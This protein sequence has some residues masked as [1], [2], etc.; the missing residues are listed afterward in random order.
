MPPS[1]DFDALGVSAGGGSLAVVGRL[2]E[3]A[4][5][6]SELDSGGPDGVA[7]ALGSAVASAGLGRGGSAGGELRPRTTKYSARLERSSSDAEAS[8]RPRRAGRALMGSGAL[9]SGIGVVTSFEVSGAEFASTE[10]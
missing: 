8:S 7:G 10:F 6:G 5:V 1:F 9:S 3:T 4:G 2:T